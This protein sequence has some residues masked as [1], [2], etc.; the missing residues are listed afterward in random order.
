MINKDVAQAIGQMQ[1]AF[2]N[3]A[4]ETREDGQGGAYVVVN[5]VDLGPV[6]TEATR[7]TWI[8]FHVS[9]QYPISDVYPHHV[10]PD[11]AR[12]DGQ[13]FG[14][15]MGVARFEGFAR[16]SV[17]FSRRTREGAWAQQSALLKLQKVIEWARTR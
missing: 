2:P 5:P 8:G 14:T 1:G 13:A 11:L 12:A 15:G 9:F 16:D 10:R 4:V 7:H 6:Y 17:Q 3:A